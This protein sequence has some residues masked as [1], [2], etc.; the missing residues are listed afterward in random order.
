[1]FFGES[2]TPV[3]SGEKREGKG[4][5]EYRHTDNCQQVLSVNTS[6]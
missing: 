5:G 2:Y 4:R 3:T 6:P 1:M